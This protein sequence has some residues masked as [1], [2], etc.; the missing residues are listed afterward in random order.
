MHA[1]G[2]LPEFSDA[3]LDP[4][5]A[6]VR[7]TET[8]M[9]WIL[10]TLRMRWKTIRMLNRR[11]KSVSDS[12]EDVVDAIFPHLSASHIIAGP[13]GPILPSHIVLYKAISAASVGEDFITPDCTLDQL[14]S[15]L[16]TPA[17]GD[18]NSDR[19]AWYWTPL[20][21]LAEAQRLWCA[22]RCPFAETWLLRIQI[23]VAFMAT[24]RREELRYDGEG[25]EWEEYVGLCRK[26]RFVPARFDR[27]AEEADVIVGDICGRAIIAGGK[28]EVVRLP[29]EE[30][31]GKATQVVFM[32]G[33]VVQEVARW[34]SGRTHITIT[35]ALVSRL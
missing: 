7:D 26:K 2:L 8:V 19:L 22:A 5:H 25:C 20:L 17:G 16:S 27:F 14:L 18:F 24:L 35:A 6:K 31:G 23:P 21:S 30:D 28:G 13:P 9:Y 32:N 34:I 12:A 4:A 29:L 11:R 1:M 3:I 10:D 15:A 33:R